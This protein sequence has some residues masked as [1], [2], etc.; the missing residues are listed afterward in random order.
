MYCVHE[1]QVTLVQHYVSGNLFKF[2]VC[3]DIYSEREYVTFI[4]VYEITDNASLHDLSSGIH[5]IRLCP[6]FWHS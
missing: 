6:R 1:T 3:Y 4:N 5:E 2:N